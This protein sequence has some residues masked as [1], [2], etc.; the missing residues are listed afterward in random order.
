[1]RTNGNVNLRSA[2]S[3]T[4]NIIRT[5]PSGTSVE[6][7]STESNWSK[8]IHNNTT[9][10]IRADLLTAPAGAPPATQSL[11]T[12]GNVNLRSSASTS[13][14]IIRTLPANTTVE[15]VSTENNWSRVTHNGTSG[16]IRA[17]LLSAS[18]AAA[19]AAIA[20]VKTTG[21]INL[22]AGPSTTTT[23]LRTLEANTTVEILAHESSGWSRV[24]VGTTNGY[25]RSDLL[26]PTSNVEMLEWSEVRHLLPLRTNLRVVD[27]RTGIAFNIRVFSRSVHADVEPPTREDTDAILRSRNGVWSFSARPVWVTVGN[28]TFAASMNGQP[29]DVS[30]IADNGI[31]GH[32]CLWFKGSASNTSNSV[33]YHRDMT[34]AIQEAYDKRPQ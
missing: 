2:A 16:F 15:V 28:R 1:M 21:R 31:N 22:R 14:S 23:L 34:N 4:S 5:I 29:H 20:S 17:D 6:V 25:I 19:E 27:V 8:V 7:V 18:G 11:K 10:F 24:R 9:G 3:T 13:S 26:S 30:T 32:F 12:V 33:T